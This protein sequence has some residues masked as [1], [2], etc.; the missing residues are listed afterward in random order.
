[1]KPTSHEGRISQQL[2]QSSASL[3]QIV[4][5]RTTLFLLIAIATWATIGTAYGQT[6][7]G[8]P[9]S[10]WQTW[11][12]A[13]DLNDSGAP[14][15]DV[16]WGA[17]GNYG[18]ANAEKNVGFCLTS[19]GDCQGVGSALFAPGPLAFWG[20]TFDVVNDQGGARD[21]S[22]Y[23]RNNGS[24]LRATLFLNAS[25]NPT[26]INEFGWFETNSSGT[27]IGTRHLLFQGTGVDQNLTPDPVG[28]TVTFTPT[29]Y[30]GYYYSDVSEPACPDGT[31]E[32]CTT[33]GPLHGCYAY[34]LFNLNDPRC[35]EVTGNQGDH[36][37][38]V[39]TA[40]PS[41]S[42][43]PMWI[44]GEDPADC[45]NQDGDCNLTMVRVSTVFNN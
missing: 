33:A 42:R 31:D 17:S 7:M 35:L 12:P 11:N 22:V 20:T 28:K 10:G 8:S 6:V 15:W 32:P 23:F 26:E 43:A 30:F 40:N 16:P 3:R 21:N 24:R 9:G 41:S 25:A 38:A 36:D 5:P 39:F 37:F 1:M 14:Y 2:A 27:V 13:T 45:A 29:R 4:C 44:V 34:S 19:T 18:G